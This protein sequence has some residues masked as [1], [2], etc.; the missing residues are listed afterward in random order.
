MF[1]PAEHAEL[2]FPDAIG[3]D[4]GDAQ[5][6]EEGLSTFSGHL[7]RLNRI[8]QQSNE[9]CM[10]L[11]DE[12]GSGTDSAD[13]SALACAVLE[14]LASKCS[15]T[16]ATSHYQEVKE[17]AMSHPQFVSAAVELHPNELAPTYELL[18]HRSGTSDAFQIARRLGM[19]QEVIDQAEAAMPLLDPNNLSIEHMRASQKSV[20]DAAAERAL[21]AEEENTT[22]RAQLEE[23][24]STEMSPES[25]EQDVEA[26][27]IQRRAI[28]ELQACGQME[29]SREEIQEKIDTVVARARMDLGVDSV[30][31][32]EAHEAPY[33]NST[34]PALC[35]G[36]IVLVGRL[37]WAEARVTD[38]KPSAKGG[39]EIDIRAGNIHARVHSNEVKL[40]RR[41][42]DDESQRQ[43]TEGVRSSTI[44][45]FSTNAD[46]N[47]LAVPSDTNTVDLRGSSPNETASQTR[48]FL[49]SYDGSILYI[50][51]GKGSGALR[52]A[53]RREVERHPR[54]LQY[55]SGDEREGGE[56]CTVIMLTS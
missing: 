8:V 32:N 5:E 40:R 20:A 43:S 37:G 3:A 11:L 14:H 29:S 1:V 38:M 21:A 13:G 39:Q 51:H 56:G 19:P 46:E 27:R 26:D 2:L 52:Q 4:I 6:L 24:E 55:R 17:L 28:D 47:F 35:I 50:V 34:V 33:S 15:V 45:E 30:A 12:P 10:L 7:E 18:W 31:R 42:Q 36:D 48:S 53:V 23:A 16:I 41:K 49:D 54:V 22:L 44:Q 25:H 9:N